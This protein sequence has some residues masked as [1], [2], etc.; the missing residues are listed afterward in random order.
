[1]VG[2]GR[3]LELTLNEMIWHRN[4]NFLLI[5]EIKQAVLTGFNNKNK[6]KKVH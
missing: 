2:K 6:K 4:W 3:N 1:M 5:S